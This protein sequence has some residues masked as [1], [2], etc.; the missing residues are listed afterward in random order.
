MRARF[1]KTLAV[2]ASSLGLFWISL[3]IVSTGIV[4]EP[5][6]LIVMVPLLYICPIVGM[7]AA[8]SFVKDDLNRGA[9]RPQLALGVVLSVG[10]FAYFLLVITHR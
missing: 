3:G 9:S 6:D 10:F 8:L 7:F 1:S 2:G 5:W 4:P